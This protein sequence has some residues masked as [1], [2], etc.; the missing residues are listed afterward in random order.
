MNKVKQKTVLSA[1][2]N[3]RQ[4][5]QKQKVQ[6]VVLSVTVIGLWRLLYD[7]FENYIY[8]HAGG[9]GLFRLYFLNNKRTQHSC[10]VIAY[11]IRNL[12]TNDQLYFAAQQ[13]SSKQV[14]EKAESS[15]CLYLYSDL[16]LRTVVVFTTITTRASPMKTTTRVVFLVRVKLSDAASPSPTTARP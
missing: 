1:K 8:I 11:I 13:V 6:S 3:L 2:I 14:D 9:K 7:M 16:T 5:L 15:G 4:I 12:S 10:L